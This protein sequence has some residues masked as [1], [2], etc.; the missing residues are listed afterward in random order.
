MEE[1]DY[2]LRFWGVRGTVPTPDATKLR[3]GGNTSCVSVALA[4][5]E[6][7]IFDCGTGIFRLG[8]EL[9]R[10]RSGQPTRYHIFF[11]HYH[12]DHID[13]LPY[14]QPLYDPKSRITFHGFK[15]DDR[16]IRETL[17][18]LIAPP[19]F[20][21]RFAEIPAE[22]DYVNITD[23]M[24]FEFDP[25]EIGT[26]PLQHPDGSLSYRI[27]HGDRR[28]VYATDHEHGDERTDQA[29]VEFSRQAEHLIYDATYHTAEYE[30]LRKG[31]GHSTWYAAVQAARAAVVKNLVL[32]HHHPEHSD[33]ELEQVLGIA[34]SE[35]PATE[36]AREGMEL[37]F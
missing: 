26:L 13:G 6:H 29:L 1:T 17:E 12:L 28:I 27:E 22:V 20:P 32:F 10:S 3:F 35:F 30:S 25:I 2:R 19:Y 9:A 15:P 11:S 34:R 14:F 37:P 18:T 23:G 5:D 16:S 36:I 31:W 8:S 33:E 24:R 21:V 4:D 7:L